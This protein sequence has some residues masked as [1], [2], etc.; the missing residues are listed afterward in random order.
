MN[1][2]TK[3]AKKGTSGLKIKKWTS[4][5]NYPCLRWS[6]YQ[7]STWTDN[8]NFLD[9][10]CPKSVFPVEKRK[11]EH[12]HWIFQIQISLETNSQLKLTIFIC[13]DQ[14]CPKKVFPD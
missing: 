9:Q 3:F 8:L 13:P 2:C 5:M 14:I 6:R 7:I 11:S 12:H 1:F 10:I 4:P